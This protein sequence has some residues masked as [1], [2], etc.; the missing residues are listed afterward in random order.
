M[1]HAMSD[2]Q[3][4]K[5][6]GGLFN[7]I[8]VTYLL[9]LVGTLSLTGF[10]FFSAYFSKDLILEI[11]YTSNNSISMYVYGIA[12]FVV[13]LTSFYSFRL[14]FY[15]FHGKCNAEEKVL[16]H[17]HESPNVMLIPLVILSFFSIFSGI[18][19]E[20]F[21]F[22]IDS[23]NFWS[24]SLVNISLNITESFLNQIPFYI[25]KLPL[26]NLLIGLFISFIL[27]LIFKKISNFLKSKLNFIYI[28]LRRKW[29]FD[30]MY[31]LLFVKTSNY[32]GSGFWKSI[33][34]ELIDNVGPNGISRFVRKIGSIFSNF[35]T[36]YLYH[37]ALSVIVGLTVFISIYFYIF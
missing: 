36:G 13:F 26:L 27:C 7:K 12:V 28:F 29:F 30:E 34:I 14:F 19:F 5:K 2:E 25:K 6:M 24:N 23:I 17:V 21:F 15:V 22:G 9:M 1:I 10:P 33:D 4:I 16:A 32:L 20:R 31:D 37:Y 3:N 11:L 18:L 8:P 35:Q